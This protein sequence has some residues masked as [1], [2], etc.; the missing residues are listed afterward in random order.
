MDN[1]NIKNIYWMLAYAFRSLNERELKK[2]SAESFDNIYDLFSV[3][4]TQELSKQVKRGLNKEYI[5]KQEEL[6]RVRGKILTQDSIKNGSIIK[7][8]LICEYDEYSSNS[9]LNKIVKTASEYLLKSKKIKDK[10]KYQKL[11]NILVYLRDVDTIDKNV[12][13]WNLVKYNKNNISY[14]ILTN[15]SYLILDGLL[16]NKEDGSIDFID[17]L[18]DQKMH[19]LYEKFIFEYYNYHHKYLS[20]RVTKIEWNI[21]GSENIQFLPKMK[22]DIVLTH[23]NKTLIIDAKYY[24]KTY[25][26]NPLYDK[27]TF[28]SN[29]LYQ[30]FSYVKNYD[31]KKTGDVSGLLLYAKSAEE[32]I[33]VDYNM[34]GNTISIC[35]LDLSQE[36]DT[37]KIRLDNIVNKLMI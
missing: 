1:I 10:Y 35:T 20:P 33:D 2:M 15:I 26:N 6:S 13:N 9:Y 36:F 31:K 11:K 34:D 30:I 14:K 12:I 24:S 27:K 4:M 18:D 23:I 5:L 3:M 16:I 19:R 22:T 29:N 25:Q 7:N 28:H 37:V 32:D 21:E 8:K 17:Y